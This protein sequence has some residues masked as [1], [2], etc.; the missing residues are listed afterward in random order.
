MITLNTEK[1]L[2]RIESWE[3]VISRP[4]F[5]A[6]LDPST[7]ELKAM[8]GSYLFK[9]HVKCGL[10][11]CHQPHGRGYLVTTID[12]SET[13]IG[14]DCG[15][16]HFDVDFETMRNAYER[17]LR[18][19]ERREQLENFITQAPTFLQKVE[20]LHVGPLGAD[21]LYAHLQV[22]TNRGR[23]VP[24]TIVDRLQKMA[25]SRNGSITVQRQAN[26]QEIENL[27]AIQGVKLK[28]PHYIEEDIGYLSGIAVLYPE[29]NLRNLLVVDLQT[30]IKRIQSLQVDSLGEYE[31]RL[32]SQWASEIDSKFNTVR[33]TIREARALLSPANVSKLELAIE[34]KEDK[35][36]FS[37][38]VSRLRKLFVDDK[39]IA[40]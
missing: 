30:G 19:K 11:S 34:K 27:E 8:I 39:Q 3:E 38:F 4:G 20:G 25:K 14:K 36:L 16:K 6:D 12:G 31:L 15:K 5:V 7:V 28:R 37:K 9:D 18:N 35:Q 33:Q 40:A 10:S 1:G 22:L 13:N 21:A 32:H 26:E 29:N 2:V 23:G 24:D 17:D